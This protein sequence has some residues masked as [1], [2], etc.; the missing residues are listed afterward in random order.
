MKEIIINETINLFNEYGYKFSMDNL[1]KNL[2]ISKKTL[3]KYF[4]SKEEL[5]TYIID[6]SFNEVHIKQ[7]QIFNSNLDTETKLRKILTTNF[8][9]EDKI[10][11]EKAKDISKYYPKLS[12]KINNRY[13]E[14]WTLVEILLIKGK[15]NGIFEYWSLSYTIA[16]LKE[17][18][19][20]VIDHISENITYTQAINLSMNSFIDSI[21]KGQTT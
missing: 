17:A 5:I 1:S 7:Q 13:R 14:E 3:Y 20:L 9:R 10:K 4:S 21:K 8:T 16:L 6:E 19:S 18:M 15:E 11:L 2:Q 12:T